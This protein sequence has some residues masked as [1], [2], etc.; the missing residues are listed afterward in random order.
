MCIHCMG[1][2]NCCLPLHVAKVLANLTT[3]PNSIT[4]TVQACPR[5]Q[6]LPLKMSCSPDRHVYKVRSA[7]LIKKAATQANAI[8]AVQRALK[9]SSKKELAEAFELPHYRVAKTLVSHKRIAPVSP[10]L[11]LKNGFQKFHCACCAC[12]PEQAHFAFQAKL[13][14]SPSSSSSSSSSSSHMDEQ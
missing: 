1:V 14:P 10:K 4:I 2:A 9:Y 11:Q 6:P 12:K 7:R 13:E 5:G 8:L 3:F